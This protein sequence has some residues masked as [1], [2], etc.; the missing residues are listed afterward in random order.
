[1]AASARPL[2]GVFPVDSLKA[3]MTGYGLTVFQG[4]KIDTFQV[5]ILGVLRGYR[6][7]ANLVLARTAGHDLDR[8]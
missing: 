1:M 4:T 3:G 7:G 8:T 2:P 6:P 5:T